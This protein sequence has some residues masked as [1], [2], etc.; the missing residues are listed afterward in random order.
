VFVGT[1]VL[2]VDIGS[3]GPSSKF[4]WAAFDAPERD[5]I[6][7][8]TDPETA[9]SELAPGLLAGA[10]A[11][12]LLEA[13]MSVPVPDGRPGAWRRLGKAREGEGNR[14]WSAGAGAAALATG[15]A[16]GAWML[17]QLA[18]SVPGLA[19]T[20]QFRSWR[21]GGA[22]LLLAEAFITAAGKPEPLPA[23]QDA[24]D[25]AAAGLALAEM[26]VGSGPLSSSVRC[27]PQDPFNLLAAMALW[28]GLR[29]D[30]GE[31]H[32][33]VSSS[34]PVLRRRHARECRAGRWTTLCISVPG[35]S[36][37]HDALRRT[38]PRVISRSQCA[39]SRSRTAGRV[40][41]PGPVHGLLPRAHPIRPALLP[42]MVR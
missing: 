27:A 13:S 35:A 25:A 12:L 36:S 16:Q 7:D 30:L 21:R 28:A 2:A 34:L 6:A 29:I 19:A 31:L 4:A 37:R 5:L 40:R 11:A 26:L 14:P 41:L 24:A 18:I 15:L 33:E 10:Q 42:A 32:A 3:V 9:V 1:R 8:G 17:R 23:G 39:A 22:Q 20:T 38:A